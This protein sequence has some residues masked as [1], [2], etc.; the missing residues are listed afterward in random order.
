[1]AV[2]S[3]SPCINCGGTAFTR[4]QSLAGLP[5]IDSKGNVVSTKEI[6]Q[7]AQNQIITGPQ[8]V[9]GQYNLVIGGASEDGVAKSVIVTLPVEKDTATE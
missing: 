3:K 1:M 2:E 9:A 6:T 4:N 7:F 5:T 8:Q